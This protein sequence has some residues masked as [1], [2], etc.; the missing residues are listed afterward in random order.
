MIPDLPA[1]ERA[2]IL[3]LAAP[4]IYLL[5]V[6]LGRVLK[7][8]AGV[9]LGV[10][11][12]L[13][14]IVVA[15]FFPLWLMRWNPLY[16][17]PF[18][19]QRE[20]GAAAVLLGA[21]FF[22]ALLRRY[23]WEIYF[24]QRRGMEIPKFVR[25]VFALII[26]LL[27]LVLVL[28]IGYGKTVTA[29]LLPSTVIVG[30]VGWAMQDLLGNVIAGVALQLGKP[31]KRGDWLIV[32]KTYGEV[33]EVN[34][35]STRLC[36]ND[37]I[38]LDVPNSQVVRNTIINL[39]Y[40]TRMHAMRI[41]LGIDSSVPPNRV[42]EVLARATASVRGVLE[43][44]PP[45]VYLVDFADSSMTYEIKYYL[46]NHRK[47]N[48]I[49]DAIHSNAWYVLRRANI[50]IPFPIRTLQI[51]PR[52]GVGAAEN[53]NLAALEISAQTLAL[54]RKQPFFQCLDETQ[55][56]RVLSAAN[57]CRYGRDERIIEQ[58]ADG[59]SMFILT[60]GSAGVF[61]RCD[62]QPPSE[63]ANVATLNAGDLFGEMSLLTGERRSATIVAASDCDVLE[64]EKS[65]IAELLQNN[66]TL[67]QKLSEMLAQRRI[68][69]ESV[70]A[71]TAETRALDSK[72]Q[73]YAKS[74]FATLRSFFEL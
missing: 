18:N 60:R 35:R 70:L 30:I 7:R 52:R 8:R 65:V 20:L 22:I 3:A 46:E 57:V 1:A 43:T 21:L 53:A 59:D 56:E 67:L 23:F 54:L 31:F 68:E 38:Y 64:I 14:C 45:K 32:D 6:A 34:W 63:A 15:L 48:E 40:P 47:F 5:G 55:T 33:I 9:H 28:S 29:V 26:F 12:Q 74:F 25:D 10:M 61:V 13:L 49:N 41:R 73:E 62:D 72:K 37:D 4:V 39:T 58:G 11:Y 19:L 42:K 24:E 51:E 2:L 66:E 44:P 50:K 36:T 71:S 16:F 69:N 27:A 17:E